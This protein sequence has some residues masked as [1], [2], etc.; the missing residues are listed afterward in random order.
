MS[1]IV[2][3]GTNRLIN[4]AGICHLNGNIRRE[5]LSRWV[6][7]GTYPSPDRV[8]NG[9]NYWFESTHEAWVAD[10]LEPDASGALAKDNEA[11][12]AEGERCMTGEDEEAEADTPEA[13]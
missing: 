6:T 9:R 8:I 2:E 1:R 11:V 10:S 13:A 7:N 4:S 3:A 12:E 5:T